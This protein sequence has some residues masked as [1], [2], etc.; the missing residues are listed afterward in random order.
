[1]GL[2]GERFLRLDQGETLSV[3]G[4]RLTASY[5]EH[6]SGPTRDAI[7]VLL[8]ADG[9]HVYQTG[10]TEYT[11]RLAAGACELQPDLLTVPINGRG[12]NMSAAQAA[13]L[14]KLVAPR[15]VIPMHYG[16][17]ADNTAD[18]AE[19]V[20]ACREIGVSARIMIAI[21]GAPFTLPAAGHESTAPRPGVTV[22][23]ILGRV[24]HGR[25]SCEGG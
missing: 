21:A 23:P 18:P 20:A 5:A 8:E 9:V 2:P 22:A 6:S 13:M 3:A 1:M 19:F 25:V 4:L 24:P 11:E 15:V 14:T 12:G 17:F 10:D 16:M 7:G